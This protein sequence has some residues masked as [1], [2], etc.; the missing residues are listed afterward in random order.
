MCASV[1][2]S[3]LSFYDTRCNNTAIPATM[4]DSIPCTAEEASAGRGCMACSYGLI[5]KLLLLIAEALRHEPN[6]R[7]QLTTT[8]NVGRRTR[9][10]ILQV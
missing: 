7:I 1:R 3:K 10:G 8:D 2:R 5:V 4:V 6:L 9:P